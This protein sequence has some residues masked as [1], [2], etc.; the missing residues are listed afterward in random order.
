MMMAMAA[1]RVMDFSIVISHNGYKRIPVTIPVSIT[2]LMVFLRRTC[3]DFIPVGIRRESYGSDLL[4]YGEA[5]NY[6]DT[7]PT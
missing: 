4:N 7:S 1:A 6:S 5:D 2:S 3:V